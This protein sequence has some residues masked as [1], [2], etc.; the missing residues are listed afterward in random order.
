MSAPCSEMSPEAFTNLPSIISK[1]SIDSHSD[2]KILYGYYGSN[3]IISW[4]S[5]PMIDESSDLHQLKVENRGAGANSQVPCKVLKQ[6]GA[7]KGRTYTSKYR[8]VHQ[9][10]P[11]QR[12]EAQFRR[13]GKPT[14]LGCFDEEGEA[15]RAYDRM[16]IWSELHPFQSS[17]EVKDAIT[18]LSSISL[19]FHYL[20]YEEDIDALRQISQEKLIQ[21]L[22]KQGRLQQNSKHDLQ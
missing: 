16:M 11:T 1:K 18:R 22:R 13:Q 10:F 2:W 5:D 7:S 14:S 17:T 8:G 6:R 20:E 12:W 9:T 21:E 3:M 4:P 15:A 19:N